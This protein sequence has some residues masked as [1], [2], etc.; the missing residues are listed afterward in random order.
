MTQVV[1]LNSPPA[2]SG[3]PFSHSYCMW[4]GSPSSPHGSGSCT[5]LATLPVASQRGAPIRNC[6]VAARERGADQVVL[7]VPRP[8]LPL[9][10]AG[11]PA[12]GDWIGGGGALLSGHGVHAERR[13]RQGEEEREQ[14][15][16]ARS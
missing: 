11:V 16:T 10:R 15:T 8:G 9:Q 1:S 12:R 2:R 14:R 5:K 13:H 7:D 6:P 4:C 3:C